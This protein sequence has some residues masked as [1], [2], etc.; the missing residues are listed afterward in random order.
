MKIEIELSEEN[1]GTFAPY[2]IIIDPQRLKSVVRLAKKHGEIARY[3]ELISYIGFATTGLFF[4]R[5][6]AE[7]YLKAKHYNF[8][9]QA[10]VWCHSGY[11]SFEYCEAIKKAEKKTNCLFNGSK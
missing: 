6:S 4:S 2:W 1:E 7:N 5:E 3:D 11:A 9:K 8:S 10:K